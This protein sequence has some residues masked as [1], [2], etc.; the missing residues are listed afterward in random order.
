M[1]DLRIKAMDYA[2]QARTG[3]HDDVFALAERMLAFLEGRAEQ[4]VAA[5]FAMIGGT[6]TTRP[7]LVQQVAADAG[8]DLSNADQSPDY[9]AAMKRDYG[10]IRFGNPETD[11]D[12]MQKQRQRD[13]MAGR[14]PV[15][16]NAYN[17][18][19]DDTKT[20]LIHRAHRDQFSEASMIV[21]D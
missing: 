17:L 14:E 15:F 21:P 3:P 11:D 20:R 12:Q 5:Q 1:D 18:P 16:V 9:R 10:D 7:D 8:P 4:K 19:D 2:L 6:A 13:A